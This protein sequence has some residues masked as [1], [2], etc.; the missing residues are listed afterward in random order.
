MRLVCFDLEGPLSPQDNAYEL[1]KL[2][3]QGGSVFEAISRYDDL[4]TLDR[5]RGYEPGDTLALIVPFLLRYNIHEADIVRLASKATLTP[6]ADTLSTWLT[7]DGWGLFCISTSYEQYALRI[8]SRLGFSPDNVASTSFPLDRFY[9]NLPLEDLSLV[10][11]VE[12]DL[13]SGPASRDEGV[14]KQRLDRFYWHDLPRTKLGAMVSSVRPRGGQ[15]KVKALRQFAR[16]QGQPLSAWVVVGDSITDFKM[17]QAVNQAGGLAVAFNS[18]EYALPYATVG[19]ASGRIHDLLPVLETWR[20]GGR[21]KVKELAEHWGASV[22]DGG[23]YLHWLAGAKD[24]TPI[25]GVHKHM[26]RLVREG[27]AKL[28]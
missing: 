6:G 5:R 19:L 18:N 15:R 27:A 10:E 3:P 16:S 13:L 12:W 20:D 28:G 9:C 14:M 11:R 2:A 1:M 24:M 26:R 22:K 17:L 21:P 25:L 23:V 7:R 4:L 8:T